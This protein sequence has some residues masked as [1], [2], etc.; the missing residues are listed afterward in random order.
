MHHER[1]WVEGVHVER[2]EVDL[3][4]QLGIR[5][6]QD[7]KPAVE[8]ETIDDVG[9]HTTT[10]VILSFK[11]RYRE[12]LGVQVSGSGKPRYASTDD[13]YVDSCRQQAHEAFAIIAIGSSSRVTRRHRLSSARRAISRVGCAN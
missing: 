9:A 3:T 12:R 2:T 13:D 10:H 11:H 8:P 4:P 7:L 6:E 1:S 5:R